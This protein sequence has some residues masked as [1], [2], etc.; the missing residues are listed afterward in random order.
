[1]SPAPNLRHQSISRELTLQMGPFFAGGACDLFVAPTDVKLSDED[2]V[3]PDLL[4]V[5]EKEKRKPTHVEGAPALVVEILSP[6]T[7]F[8]DR[9]VKLDLYARHGVREVWLVTPYPASVEVFVLAGGRYSLAR[10]FGKEDTLVS[11]TFPDLRIPLAKVFDFPLEP[12]EMLLTVRERRAP[13]A[14][15]PAAPRQQAVGAS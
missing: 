10:V 2:V 9:A 7:A 4:V 8:F 14:A 5:C 11:Q 13:Y 15:S 1:M 6:S 12:G 3:Q